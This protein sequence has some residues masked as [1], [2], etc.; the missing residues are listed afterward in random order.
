MTAKL[1]PLL[2]AL[3]TCA[4]GSTQLHAT[5]LQAATPISPADVM[6]TFEAIF[7]VHKGLRRNHVK[8]FCATGEFVGNPSAQKYSRSPLFS[9]ETIP[10]T[11]RFSLPGG[12]PNTP[13]TA[14]APRGMALQ[15]NLANGNHHNMAMV[16]APVF[17]AATPES[18]FAG[19]NAKRPDPATGKPDPE[20]LAA[21]KS[22]Y[23]DSQIQA[24][25]LA[26]HNPPPSYANTTYFG[27]HAFK[28]INADNEATTI[29]FRF[30]PR[31][32]DKEMTNEE[33]ADAP[34]NFLQD[35]F[36]ERAQ[37]GP[38]QWDLLITIAHPD[39]PE[40]DPTIEWPADREEINAGTLTLTAAET[41]ADGYCSAI[42][43]D[44]AILT[45]GFA[46]SADPFPAFRSA[47]YNFAFAQR[48]A[49]QAAAD[50]ADAEPAPAE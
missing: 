15:F 20:K 41:E 48:V 35:R 25:Y 37:Q 40:A 31:D 19:L 39:D 49:E 43:Y 3:L 44:P 24:N 10:V 1:R 36:F 12:N 27:I 4:I 13:D 32:G 2:I 23:P 30:V 21:Y 50:N 17:Q 8:G 28:L 7:G 29:R 38:I 45:D 5:E 11:A 16:N 18:F 42:T 9:G 22:A 34:A 26:A 6:D 33:L 47:V 46:L 14:R